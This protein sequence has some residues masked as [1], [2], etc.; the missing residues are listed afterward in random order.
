MA[1]AVTGPWWQSWPV[2]LAAV[3]IV[4]AGCVALA[5]R[6]REEG[7]TVGTCFADQS[8]EQALLG[9]VTGLGPELDPGPQAYVAAAQL[10]TEAW[11]DL[12]GA[13]DRNPATQHPWRDQ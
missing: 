2:A 11:E 9:A 8:G 10:P 7:D 3:L 13:R 4:A 12:R 6:R 1:A 5:L